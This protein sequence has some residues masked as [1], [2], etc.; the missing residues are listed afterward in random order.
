MRKFILTFVMVMSLCV[1]ISAVSAQAMICKGSCGTGLEYT[2]NTD[3][4]VLTI[5]GTGAMRDFSYNTVPWYSYRDYI[6]A[7]II[8]DGVTTIGKS[9]FYNCT[10]LSDAKIAESV[11]KIGSDA[12]EYCKGLTS[13]TIP[14]NVTTIDMYAFLY[15]DNLTTV[16]I[17]NN[18][19]TVGYMAFGDCTGITEIVIPRSVT[20]ISDSAFDGC[21]N[22]AYAFY[23]GSQDEISIGSNNS[24]LS[25]ILMYGQGSCGKNLS[26][27]FNPKTG[28][29]NISGTGAMSS[30]TYNTSPWYSSRNYI[31]TVIVDEEVLNIGK[32][33]FYNCNSLTLAVFR[34]GEAEL[35]I[36][37][38]NTSFT[39][40]LAYCQGVCGDSVVWTLDIETGVLTI[41]GNGKMTN[42]SYDNKAPWYKIKDYITSLEINDSVTSIGSYAFEDCG[43]LKDVTISGSI[44]EINERAF[45]DCDML[46]HVYYAGS[47]ADWE[48]IYISRTLNTDLTYYAT[49]H[50]TEEPAIP[51]TEGK[52]PQIGYTTF[53]FTP[54]GVNKGDII[55]VLVVNDG[56]SVSYA[57]TY[58]GSG[59]VT[60]EI[61][62]G[63]DSIKILVWDSYESMEPLMEEYATIE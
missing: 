19:T 11:T 37:L 27:I 56:V 24:Y 33:A 51:D 25:D 6:E 3:T 18:V 29:L 13:I 55:A 44:T 43:Y 9:A 59:T 14:D 34:G 23:E 32:Y 16:S 36:G 45:N 10:K 15:C 39:D 5:E 49:I 47:R 28:I 53:T 31:K 7:V 58:S 17:G 62:S 54:V 20:K 41:S 48:K 61:E 21:S 4:G 38:Y 42:Y 8:E 46:C 52:T 57:K 60:F 30:Y 22:I 12:F 40:V 63:F 35:S 50:Y 2:L 26:W 1:G